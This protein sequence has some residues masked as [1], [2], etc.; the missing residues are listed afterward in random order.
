MTDFALHAVEREHFLFVTGT[1]HRV[2]LAGVF[3]SSTQLE[4]LISSY[5]GRFILLDYSRVITQLTR[6]EIFS[7]TRLYETK[8]SKLHQFTI[9][10]VI[11]PNELSS[12]EFWES[13]CRQR[14]FDFKIFVSSADAE[15]WLVQQKRPLQPKL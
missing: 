7:L 14:G 6:A 12:E 5:Q 11:N 10:I 15:A 4:E 8:V 2:G 9:A 1:G 3:S 13:I